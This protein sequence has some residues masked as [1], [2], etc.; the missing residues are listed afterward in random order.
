M[1][2]NE[3]KTKKGVSVFKYFNKNLALCEK[4]T[5]VCPIASYSY[6]LQVKTF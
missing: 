2:K 6:T 4:S 5:V 1:Q 3:I